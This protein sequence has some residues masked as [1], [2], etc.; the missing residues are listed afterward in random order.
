M[1][2]KTQVESCICTIFLDRPDK[3]NAINQ[4]MYIQ[5]ADA[6]YA[7]C[8]NKSVKVI[9]LASEYE[10]FTAGNDLD[11]FLTMPGDMKDA[12]AYQFLKALVECSLPLLAA[13]QGPA[14]GIGTTL[15]LHCERVYADETAVFAMPFINL[16]LV[17]EAGSSMLLSRV[18]GYQAAADILLTGDKFDLARAVELGIVSEKVP[19]GQSL[20]VAKAYAEKLVKK[21]R[22]T[23]IDMKKLLRRA[24][25]PL[26]ERVDYE[27]E[28]FSEKIKGPEVKEAVAAFYEK[29][30]PDFSGL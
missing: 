12:A 3:K 17:A 30:Q 24:D 9:I 6:I 19:Q 29:R 18:A 10:A 2:I 21:P 5:M 14:I 28:L 1:T 8:S 23:L 27:C 7:A 20:Y 15:L 25:E 22:A 26:I 16:G 4:A 13:V 11:D